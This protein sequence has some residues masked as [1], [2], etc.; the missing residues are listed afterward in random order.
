MADSGNGSLWGTLEHTP[1]LRQRVFLRYFTAT[2]VDLVVLN[3]FIEYWQYV[4]ASSFTITLLAAILLQILLKA[5][6]AVEHR[7]AAYF[8][9][10]PGGFARFLRY[11]S[12]WLVLFGSKFVILEAL[13]FALGD[14]LR[15]TGPLDGLIVLIVVVVVMLL[16]EAAIVLFYRGRSAPTLDYRPD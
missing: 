8:N 7:V 13:N 1:S 3:L 12:A 10:K 4:S 5:T 16:V 2:L 14:S 6:I 9:A 11:F 15:F